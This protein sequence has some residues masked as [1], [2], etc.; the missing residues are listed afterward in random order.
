MHDHLIL[1]IAGFLGTLA[2]ILGYVVW[3]VRVAEARAD[4]AAT[5]PR[6]YNAPVIGAS[7]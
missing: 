4:Q 2:L 6:G 3:S 5:Q 1:F 7:A